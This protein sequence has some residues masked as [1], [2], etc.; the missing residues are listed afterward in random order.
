VRL[1][2]VQR[3]YDMILSNLNVRKLLNRDLG[4]V[5]DGLEF[6]YHQ[7]KSSIYQELK[8]L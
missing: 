6:L 8:E 1:S 4:T 2:L 3:P 5:A 7:K